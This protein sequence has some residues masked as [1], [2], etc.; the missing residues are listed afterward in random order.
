MFAL[1]FAS[2]F[3]LS[4]NRV[5]VHMAGGTPAC[6]GVLII[7]KDNPASMVRACPVAIRATQ[8]MYMS[9][10][11]GLMECNAPPAEVFPAR[12]MRSNAMQRAPSE[13]NAVKYRTGG[14]A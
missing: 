7:L 9:I 1:L 5:Y 14:L 6:I 11:C 3:P 10:A 12:G 8:S 4:L 13:G 2:L